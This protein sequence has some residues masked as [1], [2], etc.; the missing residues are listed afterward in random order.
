MLYA[1]PKVGT[2]VL[3][4]CG[5]KENVYAWPCRSFSTGPQALFAFTGPRTICQLASVYRQ[6]D[7]RIGASFG[8]ILV[9]RDQCDDYWGSGFNSIPVRVADGATTMV[10][11]MMASCQ[12]V[13]RR[14]PSGRWLDTGRAQSRDRIRGSFPRQ[15][16]ISKVKGML[17]A[18]FET[19][20]RRWRGANRP[21]E[22]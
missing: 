12:S 11:P 13:V 15:I 8:Q 5:K 7:A 2:Q 16:H 1:K 22:A 19:P 20:S 21:R 10:K 3:D 6:R 17:R 4:C 14:S 18:P 9:R